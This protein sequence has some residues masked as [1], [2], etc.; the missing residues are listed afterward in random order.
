[1][2]YL[3]SRRAVHYT[4]HPSKPDNIHMLHKPHIGCNKATERPEF[5]VPPEA[6]VSDRMA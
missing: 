1:L 4:N 2:V 5:K 6:A 3:K